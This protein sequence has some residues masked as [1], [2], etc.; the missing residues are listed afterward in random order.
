MT[1]I[2]GLERSMLGR[3]SGQTAAR[4]RVAIGWLRAAQRDALVDATGDGE[5]VLSTSW[6]ADRAAGLGVAVA[7]VEAVLTPPRVSILM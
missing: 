5:D 4:L 6:A 1:A 2:T 3:P 7:R